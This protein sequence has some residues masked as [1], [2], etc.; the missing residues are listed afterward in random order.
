MWLLMSMVALSSKVII[1][2]QTECLLTTI[3]WPMNRRRKWNIHHSGLPFTFFKRTESYHLWHQRTQKP[4]CDRKQT[5]HRKTITAQKPLDGEFRKMSSLKQSREWWLVVGKMGRFWS[6]G[7]M[8]HAHN[9][10]KYGNH[11]TSMAAVVDQEFVKEVELE[12]H[13]E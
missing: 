5:W 12:L 8:F 9:L 13:R 3:G 1:G 10:S 6:Q 2:T 4:S 7:S 11:C